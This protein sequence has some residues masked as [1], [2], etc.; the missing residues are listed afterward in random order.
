[1]SFRAL[2]IA[3]HSTAIGTKDCHGIHPKYGVSGFCNEM[4]EGDDAPNTEVLPEPLPEET[5]IGEGR[6]L[7]LRDADEWHRRPIGHWRRRCVTC[8]NRNQ[9]GNSVLGGP[10][11]QRPVS[12]ERDA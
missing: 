5:F 7:R 2:D 4:I 10:P 12:W 8:A 11:V 9:R 1:M 6:P 3:C